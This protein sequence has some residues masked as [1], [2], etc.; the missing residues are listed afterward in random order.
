MDYFSELLESYS[1]L[2]KRT[3]KL[4]YINEAEEGREQYIDAVFQA[5]EA[6]FDNKQAQKGLGNSSNIT[7]EY[8]AGDPEK[9]TGEKIKVSGSNLGYGMSFD[10]NK[11]AN[12]FTPQKLKSKNSNG[13]RILGAWAGVSEKDK[14]P[15]TPEQEDA[16]ID[17]AVKAK[18][19]EQAKQEEIAA[20]RASYFF[21]KQNYD[22]D[23]VQ[24][25]ITASEESIKSLLTFCSTF[26][27]AE[28]PAPDFCERAATFITNSGQSS[29]IY[30]IANGKV[31]DRTGEA[32]GDP[33]PA[34]LNA[35]AEN[36]RDFLKVL[37]EKPDEKSCKDLNNKV[38][39][40]DGM[41]LVY[42]K[43][44]NSETGKPTTGLVLPSSDNAL[45]QQ[46]FKAIDS[47]CKDS[48]GNSYWK[49]EKLFTQTYNSKALN[50]IRG[51]INEMALVAAVEFSK[52]GPNSSEEDRKEVIRT[53]IGYVL[54]KKGTLLEFAKSK[55][56]D[57]ERAATDID[58]FV[59]ELVLTEQAELAKD[60]R[61]LIRYAMNVIS[62]HANF[63][64]LVKA[65]GAYDAS[66]QGGQGARSD[67]TLFWNTKEG[68]IS[69]AKILRLDPNK[70]V[71]EGT[72]GTSAEGK[73]EIGMGQK[74]KYGGV[75]DFK[76][77]EYNAT[78]RRRAAFRGE[79]KVG[80][81]WAPGF[82][83][84]AE[85][86]QFGGPTDDPTTE[87]GRRYQQ[88]MD[89]EDKLESDVEDVLTSLEQGKFYIDSKGNLK[90]Q[91]GQ[92]IC[93]TIAKIFKEKVGYGDTFNPDPSEDVRQELY[94]AFVGKEQQNWSNKADREYAAETLSRS[95]RLRKVQMA[96]E[97]PDPTERQAARDWI[98][99]TSLLT[100][101]N[102]N[103]IGQ[104]QTS[105]TE[106]RSVM[107]D[108]N[109]VLKEMCK[110]QDA[111]EFNFGSRSSI[112][113]S[114]NGFNIS[115]GFEGTSA[116]KG[117]ARTRDTRTHLTMSKATATDPRIS[118][119]IKS[120]TKKGKGGS[121]NADTMYQFLAGQMKLLEE[122]LNSSK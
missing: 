2:K 35:V 116:P 41:L 47:A 98:I 27:S 13:H 120:K 96:L 20:Q 100:G 71:V 36:H 113:I 101:G 25:A 86:Q 55:L 110:N 23:Q 52:L 53:I 39:F 95:I 88:M 109:A 48:E 103:D 121:V 106:G 59:E 91:S 72:P 31:Y 45:Y 1:K 26:T 69:A 34:L 46:A 40:K 99:R 3:F 16:E 114:I 83:K 57:E 54:E 11:W 76:M 58:G 51:T 93:S 61:A 90:S 70:A 38:G 49:P 97:S 62:K 89:F 21:E 44:Y 117:S 74:D 14:G 30:K 105:Y 102:V 22:L 85:D 29:F 68:A 63:A 50:T 79:I 108:H 92:S 80:D 122:I 43:D 5:G 84:W 28:V 66:K 33:P 64:K 7:I 17:S 8:I 118:K 82:Y 115:L 119:E 73:F 60:D 15:K 87:Q 37:Y 78:A 4:T 19:E 12:V 18:E 65:D 77:G 112:G 32:Q 75:S 111:V 10:R 81:K 24:A 67:T 42:G 94:K 107:T 9:R 104:L 56:S 6:V